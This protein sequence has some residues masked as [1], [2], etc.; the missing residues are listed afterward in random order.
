MTGSSVAAALA[1]RLLALPRWF[2][3]LGPVT[4]MVV[5]W[6]SSSQPPSG[7]V[8]A[9]WEAVVHN[10]MHVVAFGVLALTWWFALG[11]PARLRRPGGMRTA[12]LVAIACSLAYGLVDELHQ[13]TVPGRVPSWGDVLSDVAGAGLFATAASH[14]CATGPSP[15][16]HLLAW[17][18]AAAAGVTLATW[19][20]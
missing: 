14:L 8:G 15:R 6:Y 19:V 10:A 17:A 16:R 5:L 13:A 11:D 9:T 12:T 20:L 7:Q 1:G 3:L 4:V 18:L 2:R